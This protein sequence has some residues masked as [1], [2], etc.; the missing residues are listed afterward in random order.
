M[1]SNKKDILMPQ[2]L[3]GLRIDAAI[4][5]IFPEYSRGRIQ[6]W[7]RDGHIKVD[8]QSLAPK[9]KI[10]GGENISIDFQ[11]D[12]E[13]KQFEAED[14]IIEAVYEDDHILVINK[15]A[16]LVVHPGAGNWSGTLLNGL[17]H[18][19]PENKVLARAGIVHRL[20]KDTSGLMVVS[21]NEVAQQ[22]LIKQLQNKTVKR[23]Y[24]CIV[25]GQVWKNGVVKEP[26]GR[27][28]TVR[29][30]MAVN[31]IHGKESVTHYEVL[32]RFGHHSYLRCNLE[33][34][35]THQ[36]RVH[37]SHV[38][39]PIV[40]DPVYGIKKIIPVRELSQDLK[41]EVFG[42]PRQALHAIGLGLIH[43]ATNEFMRWDIDLPDDMK[44]LLELIRA[45]PNKSPKPFM[46][47][48]EDFDG[49]VIY[50]SE[51]LDDV[52]DDE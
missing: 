51:D 47:S 48:D 52:F 9:K 33:T 24:R 15:P 40:G 27:H 3:S 36:I 10:I 41:D 28:P 23:E 14:M 21:K 42:F 25:W 17:L 34:G 30:K 29:V 50:T 16:G 22:H 31:K 32:E 18:H 20:D 49:E 43:P 39:A 7:I 13:V 45:E 19:F 5:K 8:G 11:P 26:I 35:R 1:A 2:E 6:A 37:M 12:D 44:K 46:L 4:H 38:Q